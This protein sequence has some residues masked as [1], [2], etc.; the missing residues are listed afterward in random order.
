MW[1]KIYLRHHAESELCRLVVLGALYQQLKT[2]DRAGRL[3]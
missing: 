3:H 1:P 2:H